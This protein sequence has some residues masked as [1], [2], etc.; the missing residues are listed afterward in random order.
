M[1]NRGAVSIFKVVDI[2][3]CIRKM[4]FGELKCIKP[5]IWLQR[6]SNI[7]PRNP[8][9]LDVKEPPGRTR[10]RY[11]L[12]IQQCDQASCPSARRPSFAPANPLGSAF[13]PCR[14]RAGV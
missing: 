4:H 8:C 5:L 10:A 14:A 12:P 13:G 7:P 9:F 2:T 3:C 6:F 1:L 11:A